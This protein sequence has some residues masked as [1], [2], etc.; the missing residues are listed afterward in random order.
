VPNGAFPANVAIAVGI[1]VALGISLDALLPRIADLPVA[2]HRQSISKSDV[3]FT[4]IDDT[5]NS[6]PAGAA[7]GLA[8]LQELDK[9]KKVVVTPGMIELGS[10]QEGANREFATMAASMAD[11][12]VIVGRT[13]LKPLLEGSGN[14]D[15]SVSVVASREEAVAWVRSNLGPGDAVLYE[16]DLPD[17]YP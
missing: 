11:H 12:L 5:F 2:R 3:G 6:N 9:G 17:H 7:R 4:I 15:A 1:G 14:G 10:V 8:L 13:N 16:N